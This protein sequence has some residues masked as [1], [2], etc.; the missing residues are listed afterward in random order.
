MTEQ[1]TQIDTA[2][3]LIKKYM[4]AA[5]GVG[6][7]PYPMLDMAVLVGVQMKMLH[8]LAKIYEVEFSEEL[9]TKVVS[10]CLGSVIPVSLSLGLNHWLRFIPIYGWLLKGVSTSAFAGAFTYAIG[11]LFIQHFES[12]G[13][14]LTLDPQQVK[15]YFATHFEQGREEVSRNFVGV[16]P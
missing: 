6:L 10:S 7:V 4:V 9:S 11:K 15:D 14:F 12:G 3:A 8:S 1:T 2:E 5:L 13:T 16:K